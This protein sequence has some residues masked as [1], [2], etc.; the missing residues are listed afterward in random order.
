M[1]EFDNLLEAYFTSKDT[2]D[3]ENERIALEVVEKVVQ[4]LEDNLKN[5]ED[6][7]EAKLYQSYS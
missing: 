2:D 6:F 3:P 1:A 4:E 7:N 5:E